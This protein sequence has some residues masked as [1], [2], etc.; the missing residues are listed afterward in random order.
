M[1]TEAAATRIYTTIMQTATR[2]TRM[3]TT[4][5]IS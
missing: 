1:Q 3:A 4:I 5:V 2:M